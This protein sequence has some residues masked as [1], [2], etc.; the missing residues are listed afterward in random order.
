MDFSLI[1][2]TLLNDVNQESRSALPGAPVVLGRHTGRTRIR[3]SA[4]K[5]RL[6][7]LLHQAAWA[8]EP[9]PSTL[10]GSRHHGSG[11]DEGAG[12]AAPPVGARSRPCAPA[13]GLSRCAG[14]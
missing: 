7:S 10:T 3:L 4:L 5:G 14:T 6:A 13:A 2:Y 1:A 8:I 9:Q 12:Y 11:P